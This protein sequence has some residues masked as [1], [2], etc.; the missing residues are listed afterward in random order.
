MTAIMPVPRKIVNYCFTSRGLSRSV[1]KG[2]FGKRKDC[3]QGNQR[4]YTAPKRK[5]WNTALLPAFQ[6]A[7]LMVTYEISSFPSEGKAPLSRR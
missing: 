6:V 7:T 4:C 1:W 3:G 5:V 2:T